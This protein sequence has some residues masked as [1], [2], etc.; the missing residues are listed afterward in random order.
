MPV[1]R[2]RKKKTKKK[3]TGGHS[4]VFR[5]GPMEIKR[6]GNTVLLQNH[7]TEEEHGRYREQ[8]KEGRPQAYEDIKA[9][10][11]QLKIKIN[12]YDKLIVLSAI[13]AF[14]LFKMY[15]DP[16][17]DGKSEVALEYMQSIVLSDQENIN[18]GK[19]PGPEVL[20]S[21]Y[22]DLVEIRWQFNWYFISESIVE[23]Y[24]PVEAKVRHEMITDAL[25]VRGEGYLT[26][27]N[28]LYDELFS[29][30]DTILKD[31]FGFTSK[32]IKTA[33]EHLEFALACRTMM[34][35]GMPHPRQMALY[36]SW[37]RQHKPSREAIYSGEHFNDFNRDHP[38]ILV[39]NNRIVLYPLNRIDT[40]KDLFRIR[41]LGNET[42][43]RVVKALSLKIGDNTIFKTP[44]KFAYEVLNAS[45]IYDHPF[46]EDE[47]GN[48]YLFNVN[49]GARNLFRITQELL[50]KADPDY[51]NTKFVGSKDR[52][53]RDTYI[54]R[55]VCLLLE[56]MM[57]EVKFYSNATYTYF[58]N[59]I[60]LKCA[61]AADGNYELDVLGISDKATYLVEVKAGEVGDDAKRGAIKSI[62]SDL[63]KVVGD[64]I[65]QSYRAERYI[66][67]TPNAEFVSVNHD[68]VRPISDKIIKISVSFSYAGTVISALSLLQEFGVIDKNS[69]FAWTINVLD[70]MVFSELI[71]S[72]VEF[73]DYLSKRLPLYHDERFVSLDEVN[74][75]GFYFTKDMKVKKS[76]Q[77]ASFLQI[78]NHKQAIDQYYDE[79]GPKPFKRK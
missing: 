15:T 68:I 20:T 14:C 72:E 10:I 17:D 23:K 4:D 53:S 27:I 55:K 33:F 43:E 2:S 46:V 22:D 64:A 32:D 6:K 16:Q 12:S 65:C 28:Q 39:D 66:K 42:E 59:E 50:K 29:P 69:D 13:S 34:P 79:G 7:M 78:D 19:I 57:P 73:L 61:K 24:P 47:D 11:A 5:D 37:V 1:S 70:L 71:G 48:Y 41:F 49:L 18:I 44:E 60:D 38:E 51:Y 30:H 67:N 63:S 21:I 35:D 3:S 36:Q 9:L 40:S 75:L 25:Y 56:K 76:L 58:E 74:M 8:V 52:H 31:K 45:K 77:F 54:E 26:H 62:K